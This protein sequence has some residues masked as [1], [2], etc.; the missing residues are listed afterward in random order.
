MKFS[1]QQRDVPIALVAFFLGVAL[2]LLILQWNRTK[3]GFQQKKRGELAR[4]PPPVGPNRPPPPPHPGLSSSVRTGTPEQVVR[5]IGAS[6]VTLGRRLRAQGVQNV[7]AIPVVEYL[8]NAAS[9]VRVRAVNL[10]SNSKI[11][12]FTANQ[13]VPIRGA[14]TSAGVM[15][16]TAGRSG[17]VYTS[18]DNT[19]YVFV[20]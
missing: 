1:F 3:E 11:Y 13:W 2:T 18:S 20:A 17:L 5:Q 6:D 7:S 10:G 8:T 19:R 12:S 4:P 14:Q 15:T 9:E 16:I